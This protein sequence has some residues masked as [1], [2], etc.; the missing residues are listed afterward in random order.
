V[1]HPDPGKPI[2]IHFVIDG[3]V[4]GLDIYRL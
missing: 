3:G 2:S 4:G 1:A